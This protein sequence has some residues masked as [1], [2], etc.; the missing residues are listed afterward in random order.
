MRL[1]TGEVDCSVGSAIVVNEAGWLVTAAHMLQP[2]ELH[3]RHQPDIAAYD[4]QSPRSAQGR[5]TPPRSRAASRPSTTATAGSGTARSGSAATSG[6]CRRSRFSARP[7]SRSGGSR[8]SIL[9]RDR[10]LSDVSRSGHDQERRER[11]PA[12]LSV[13]RDHRDLRRRATGAFNLGPGSLPIPRFPNEGIDHPLPRLGDGRRDR[14][15]S[16]SRRRPPA[17][18]ARAAGPIFDVARR[19][20]RDAVE[21]GSPTARVQPGGRGRRPEGHRAPVHERR[22]RGHA[23]TMLDFFARH[24]VRRP[25][26]DA[27]ALK[28]GRPRTPFARR[29]PRSRA[30]ARPAPRLAPS[31]PA[32]TDRRRSP[33]PPPRSGSRCGRRCGWD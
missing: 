19:G 25:S 26:P 4:Q 28:P 18:A 12:R 31:P 17:F 20:L 14:R 3:R 33:V 13:P 22:P 2:L 1:H 21:D 5:A 30:S 32:T 23:Q 24:G 10:R 15:S 9:P 29:A 16:R 27:V 7:I 6:R 11:L 8:A